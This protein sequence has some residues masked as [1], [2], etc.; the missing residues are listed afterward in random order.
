MISNAAC[1]SPV[2]RDFF[3]ILEKLYVF[4]TNSHPRLEKFKEAKRKLS[5]EVQNIQLKRLIDTRW[6]C[7]IDSVRAVKATYPA[8][9]EALE[10]I[11]ESEGKPTEVAEARGLITALSTVEFLRL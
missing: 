11:E 3:G 2:A 9:L 8:I 4:L 7:R 6:S 1:V 5:N 10:D